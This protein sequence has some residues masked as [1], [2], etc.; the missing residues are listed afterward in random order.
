M[1]TWSLSR[2]KL[3]EFLKLTIAKRFKED[4]LVEVREVSIGE[5]NIRVGHVNPQV[6]PRYFTVK[7]TQTRGE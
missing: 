6:K 4:T 1:E 7:V 2:K 3:T 5:F